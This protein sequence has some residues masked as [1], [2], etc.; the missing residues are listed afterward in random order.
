[1]KGMEVQYRVYILAASKDVLQRAHDVAVSKIGDNGW[2]GT[3]KPSAYVGDR[4]FYINQYDVGSYIV[5][6]DGH[7]IIVDDGDTYQNCAVCKSLDDFVDFVSG[8]SDSSRQ[9]YD[10]NYSVNASRRM[11]RR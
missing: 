4:A 2:V 11:L 1:M 8:M 3:I 6:K 10:E 7:T 5:Y 9:M